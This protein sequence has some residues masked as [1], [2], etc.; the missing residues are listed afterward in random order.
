MYL[1]I[2]IARSLPLITKATCLLPRSSPS[3][4][5]PWSSVQLRHSGSYRQRV[6]EMKSL[7]GP[8]GRLEQ[9]KSMVGLDQETLSHHY[10]LQ[11]LVVIMIISTAFVGGFVGYKI[12]TANWQKVGSNNDGTE[13]P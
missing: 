13:L 11:P 9:N 8:G 7:Y 6:N 1:A 10:G 2:R 3:A 12:V 4:L 5:T